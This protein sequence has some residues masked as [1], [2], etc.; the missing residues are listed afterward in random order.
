MNCR[1]NR[2]TTSETARTLQ[3]LTLIVALL[4]GA[5][6]SAP[7]LPPLGADAR[8]LAFGDSLTWGTGAPRDQSYPAVLGE[9]AGR[10]VI[11]AGVPGEVTQQGLERLPEVL[12]EHRPQL[13]ILC[14]GGNDMLRKKSLDA[15]ADNLRRMIHL[16]RERGIPVVLV[17]VP[18]PGLFLSSADFY[19]QIADE[20]QLPYQGEIIAAIESDRELK[21]D[22]IHPNGAGYRKLAEALHEL[23]IES[24]ALNAG[25]H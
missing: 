6:S 22:A 25:P 16:A 8:I 23:L 12:D 10:T 9:L 4:L 19:A 13:L 7:E 15:A 5:C 24:G 2:T 11:N 14:H 1:T 18:K 3:W 21:S 17:G 20:L